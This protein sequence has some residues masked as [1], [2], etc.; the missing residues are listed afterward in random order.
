MQYLPRQ[1]VRR[2]AGNMMSPGR[3]DRGFAPLLFS[4]FA[5][6]VQNAPAQVA[7]P[8]YGDAFTKGEPLRP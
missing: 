1:P 5:V 6:S 3:L 8:P 2:A 4:R 7:R